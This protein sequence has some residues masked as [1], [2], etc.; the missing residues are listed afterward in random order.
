MIK[1]PNNRLLLI[2][3][4]IT[5]I[6]FFSIL[7][8]QLW[9]TTPL[10]SFS[11]A[12]LLKNNNQP[13]PV[14][15]NS[16]DYNSSS[17]F[18]QKNAHSSSDNSGNTV[19]V[20]EQTAKDTPLETSIRFRKFNFDNQIYQN[21][22]TC[23]QQLS[24]TIAAPNALKNFSPSVTT[25]PNGSFTISW[26][27][28]TV[29]FDNTEQSIFAQKFNSRCEPTSEIKQVSARGTQN[30]NSHIASSPNSEFSVITWVSE[31]QIFMKR[32][33]KEFQLI[34]DNPIPINKTAT[35]NIST[36]P[37]VAINSFNEFIITWEQANIDPTT[38]KPLAADIYLQGF[39]SAGFSIS[40]QNQIV[41]SYLDGEQ[42]F[43][44]ITTNKNDFIIT[45]EGEG[46]SDQNGIFFK[47]ISRCNSN[48]CIIA[49]NE[50]R[51]NPATEN[52]QTNPSI[53]SDSFGNFSIAWTESITNNVFADQ[54][55]SNNSDQV[56]NIYFQQF[57]K[58]LNTINNVHQINKSPNSTNPQIATD[59]DGD[60]VISWQENDT[61][62]FQNLISQINK[63]NQE[64]T[65]TPNANFSQQ[66]VNSESTSDGSITVIAWD[67]YGDKDNQ[68]IYFNIF[69]KH[70]KNLTNQ[71]G[72]L[73]NN[74]TQG[75]QSRPQ[76]GMFNNGEFI[77]CW[78]GQGPGDKQ[79]VFFQ[80]F[81]RDGSRNGRI[82]NV[83]TTTIGS[84]FFCD[85]ATQK[86]QVGNFII[87]WDGN[88]Q[89]DTST[90]NQGIAAKLYHRFTPFPETLINTRTGDFQGSPAT[91][92]SDK[93]NIIITW[94]EDNEINTQNIFAQQFTPT[95]T[96]INDNFIVN[97]DTTK[98][99][100]NPQVSFINNDLFVITWEETTPITQPTSS[101]FNNEETETT[102]ST[103][104][105][106]AKQ[107]QFE[108]N[109]NPTLLQDE[110]PVNTIPG[111]HLHPTIISDN[112]GNFIIGWNHN[113]DIY[114]RSFST[115][116]GFMPLGQELRINS[117]IKGAQHSPALSIAK[118][119]GRIFA[120][121][122]GQ[123]PKDQSGIHAQ[124]LTSLFATPEA[125][126]KTSSEQEITAGGRALIIPSNIE[127]A[128]L[129]VSFKP[130]E[131]RVIFEGQADQTSTY[132]QIQDL[133]ADE[134]PFNISISATDL[135]S[136]TDQK[137]YIP[138]KN[139]Y[140]KHFFP[141]TDLPLETLK[142]NS[143]DFTLNNEIDEFQS[144]ET[145]QILG[146]GDGKN[147]GFWRFPVPEIKINIPAMTP[148][149]THS[150]NI[151]FSLN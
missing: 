142:G 78:D 7:L 143:D 91:A 50:I 27:A 24:Q 45:W 82:E 5:G 147:F 4:I 10:N 26:T 48:E 47:K 104:T 15:T 110:F 28:E 96:P 149:G 109:A 18:T 52:Y 133:L 84:Q 20:W 120:Q 80:K 129:D 61:I 2:L 148:P 44:Q 76:V 99:Q 88:I 29:N 73:A 38:K 19:I 144:L 126:F 23:G 79:G 75:P 132:I 16:A 71:P 56:T 21:L 116:N 43:P 68:G 30:S 100:Q 112:K 141:T 46:N 77:I 145:P 137:T 74:Y 36:H 102:P 13:I 94:S 34:D 119:N 125:F 121:W 93:G 8:L 17:L 6:S 98:E 40:D 41:N 53:A 85:I 51:A 107:Y 67:G 95:L 127:L 22:A 3:T 139:I 12:S 118:N 117:T 97:Q 33:N 64:F 65:I 66:N 136:E 89:T 60:T 63:Y 106:I 69:D 81:N 11:Q 105:I 123:G 115:N 131:N 55:E 32:I 57:T 113:Q 90:D 62:I 87:V 37:Q 92:I 70:G 124:L 14:N 54:T 108:Q 128:T 39:S 140:I 150:G 146:Y 135:I 25:Y 101:A 49:A 59:Q 72:I 111:I 1:Q 134:N 122:V 83:N 151:I 58:D 35:P 9:E 42:H 130:Q 86:N 103:S 31:N 114:I 138:A